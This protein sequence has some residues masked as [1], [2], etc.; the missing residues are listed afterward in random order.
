MKRAVLGA[1]ALM[2]AGAVCI[3]VFLLLGRLHWT[4]LAS[5]ILILTGGCILASPVM[6][7]RVARRWRVSELLVSICLFEIA[8]GI[9]LY[10]QLLG[11]PESWQ[12]AHGPGFLVIFLISMFA[13][14]GG[15]AIPMLVGLL[16]AQVLILWIDKTR[17]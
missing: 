15:A 13:I 1:L 4:G 14:G 16:I 12:S 2:L 8:S 6:V 10:V 7:L 17:S 11:D 5:A 9:V 3:P